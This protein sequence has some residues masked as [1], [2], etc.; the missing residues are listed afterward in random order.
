LGR[1]EKKEK[2]KVSAEPSVAVQGYNPSDLEGRGKKKM[3][4]KAFPEKN[5][6]NSISKP[7]C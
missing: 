2:S 3:S 6:E 1:E 4:C 7:T 5:Y